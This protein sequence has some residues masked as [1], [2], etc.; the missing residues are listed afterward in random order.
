MSRY[1]LENE[2]T[3]SEQVMH[4]PF[5]NIGITMRFFLVMLVYNN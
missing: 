1:D 2:I 5:H 4:K 3:L